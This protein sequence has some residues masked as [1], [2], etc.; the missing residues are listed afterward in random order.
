MNDYLKT[1]RE[2]VK[3]SVWGASAAWTVP[4][5][6]DRTFAEI[7][8]KTR[9]LAVQADSGKDREILV[10]LQLA[11]GNDGLNT[12]VPC[13]DDAYHKARPGLGK[14]KT[15]LIALN[16]HLGLNKSL[17]Y[18]G[19][20]YGEGDLAVVQGVGYPNP[21]R[22]HFVATSVWETADPS[23]KSNTGWLGRYFD[24]EC[25]GAD[26]T[27]GISLKKTQ[28][29]AFGAE[30]NPGICL[31]TPE[32]YR[33]MHAGGDDAMAEEMFAS[34]NQPGE[35]ASGS[36]I[37]EVGKAGGKVGEDSLA[38]LERVALDAQVSS[39][40]I[41]EV[42]AKY[43]SR[44]RYAGTPIARS[45]NLVS[46]M[47][48][49]GLPT[50]VYYVSHGGF[51][52]HQGQEGRH[53]NLLGQMDE[54]LK[55]FFTDLKQQGNYDRVTVLTFSEFGRRVAQN[56][57]A[58]TDHG[59]GSCL[60]VAGGGVKGG[61]YGEHPSLTE[62]DQGD[63]KHSVD[64]RSVYATVLEKWLK[65]NSQPSVKGRYEVMGFMG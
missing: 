53:D 42:A 39:K 44:V 4:M 20:L 48:A 34:L 1:R 62:L 37:E 45:L 56:A 12:V 18:L 46:R 65:G 9:D 15:E 23:A 26:P 58:G 36:S 47:I 41:L 7:D 49:G 13:G 8:G 40:R 61:L 28:P 55:A 3:T 35:E 30:K 19:E 64:F 5:F 10:V 43:Q 60:F 29:E 6:L 59:K 21:N 24:S 52:T 50:R 2:F 31:N 11:G 33:W 54:A 16:D 32:L 57:S 63:L 17:G 51:D 38:F 22:S 27:V 14:E 25:P